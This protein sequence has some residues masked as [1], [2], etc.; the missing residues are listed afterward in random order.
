MTLSPQHR[1]PQPEL[2]PGL[3]GQISDTYLTALLS[4][5]ELTPGF[6]GQI[7]DTYLTAL[8]SQPELTPP[9]LLGQISDTYMTALLSQPE[10]ASR[11][12][13]RKLGAHHVSTVKQLDEETIVMIQNK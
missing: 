4:Q 13:G 10:P 1:H 2:T 3:L 9:G 8:L 11:V 5:P 6:L 7:S 12:V